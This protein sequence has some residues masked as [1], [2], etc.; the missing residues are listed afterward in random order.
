MTKPEDFIKKEL[1]SYFTIKEKSIGPPTQYL[2]NKVSQVAMVNGAKCLSFNSSQ[3][4]QGS[5]KNV[6]DHLAKTGDKLPTRNPSPWTSNYRPECDTTPELSPTKAAYYQSLI[7]VLRWIVE[8]ERA[9]VCME[10]SAMA[11]MMAS[12]REGHLQQLF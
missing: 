8:L 9:D 10:V 1:A 5:V 11:S 6:E 2:G 4:V 3:Y 7:G 12:P